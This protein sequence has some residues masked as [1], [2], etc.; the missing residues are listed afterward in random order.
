MGEATAVWMILGFESQQRPGIF[1]FTTASRPAL[2]PIQYPVQL[3][4]GA[5]SLRVKRPEPEADHSSPSSAEVKNVSY[6][7]TP[8]VPLHIV[9]FS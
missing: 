9:V 3:E 8:P 1:L 4:L 6:T 7:S 5:L 2:G